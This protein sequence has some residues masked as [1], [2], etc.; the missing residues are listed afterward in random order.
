MQMMSCVMLG[1]LG[2]T[3]LKSGSPITFVC[4]MWVLIIVLGSQYKCDENHLKITKYENN[5]IKGAPGCLFNST[6]AIL[7]KSVHSCTT[8]LNAINRV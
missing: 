3:V 1:I 5:L 7:K 8:I 2:T 6:K 4:C